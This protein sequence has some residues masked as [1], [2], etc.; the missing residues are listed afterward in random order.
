M[1][2]SVKNLFSHKVSTLEGLIEITNRGN[3]TVVVELHRIAK[4]ST[5]VDLYSKLRFIATTLSGKRVVYKEPFYVRLGRED[6]N[7]RK[8]KTLPFAKK[9]VQEI[10]P[11]VQVDLIVP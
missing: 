3:C 10:F 9:R 1:L 6:P 5:P 4:D 11:G 2:Q 8:T 7:G